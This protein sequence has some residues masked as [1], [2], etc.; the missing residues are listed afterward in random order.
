MRPWD[1]GRVSTAVLSFHPT[2]S[3]A[4]A[5]I[6]FAFGRDP[7]PPSSTARAC[8]P[9]PSPPR[10]LR[11]GDGAPPPLANAPSSRSTRKTP[12]S[13]PRGSPI[14]PESNPDRLR[15]RTNADPKDR[16]DTPSILGPSL[17]AFH[18]PKPSQPSLSPPLA[19][20]EARW[21]SFSR[22]AKRPGHVPLR[23]ASARTA[24]RVAWDRAF[25]PP[26]QRSREWNGSACF[27]NVRGS[28][29]RSHVAT[30]GT[31]SIHLHSILPRGT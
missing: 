18:A 3:V 2:P 24:R 13:I 6:R 31:G 22:R 7:F 4:T 9:A 23:T 16:V 20:R 21:T 17:T 28:C 12:F 25:L 15:F 10:A 30:C 27:A 8:S 5:A 11:R 19:H 1:G 29:S 26:P 14:E